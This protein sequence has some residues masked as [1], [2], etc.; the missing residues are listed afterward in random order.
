M[1]IIATIL[2]KWA[3][4]Y[5]GFVERNYSNGVYPLIAR[6]QRF[7]FGWLPI[8]VGDLFYAFLGVV[9]LYKVLRFFNMLFRKRLTRRYFVVALQQGIFI[10]LFLCSR[11]HGRIRALC[12][13]LRTSPGH[14]AQH[15]EQGNEPG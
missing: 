15:D 4:W 3:S 12:H 6:V 10:L 7:L 13:V 14:H 5:P 1:L 8:S 9:I 11:L 2:I